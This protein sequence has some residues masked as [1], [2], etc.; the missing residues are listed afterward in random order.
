VWTSVPA[1]S[2]SRPCTAVT[3]RLTSGCAFWANFFCIAGLSRTRS[4][5][6][7]SSDGL[8]CCK[9]CRA[10]GQPEYL[11]RS[12]SER[13]GAHSKKRQR[14]RPGGPSPLS[15]RRRST[16]G[17]QYTAGRR[18]PVAAQTRQRAAAG[19]HLR[20]VRRVRGEDDHAGRRARDRRRLGLCPCFGRRCV[21]A[22]FACVSRLW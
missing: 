6:K 22:S 20:P 13:R 4:R 1:S 14:E 21:V 17:P 2:R 16:R 5:P 3:P 12:A 7:P 10:G 18:G 11:K 15:P 19:R 9:R 8:D